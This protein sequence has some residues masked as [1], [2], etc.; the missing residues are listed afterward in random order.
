[1]SPLK[2]PCPSSTRR[3]SL[4][5]CELLLH[6]SPGFFHRGVI[7]LVVQLLDKV[8]RPQLENGR[9]DGERRKGF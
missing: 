6:T 1:M 2:T 7:F 3:G 4:W 5:G 9:G 8:D